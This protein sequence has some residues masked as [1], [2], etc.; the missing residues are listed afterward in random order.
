[1][2]HL[3][4]LR[5]NWEKIRTMAKN[6]LA[7]YWV[8]IEYIVANEPHSMTFSVVVDNDDLSLSSYDLV[9]RDGVSTT[10]FSQYMQQLTTV[11]ESRWNQNAIG[12]I[13]ATLYRQLVTDDIPLI[14]E[15][16]TVNPTL[17]NSAFTVLA[18]QASYMFYDQ[19]R[20]LYRMTLLDG[21]SEPFSRSSYAQ[22]SIGNQAIVDF[23]LA[24]DSCIV[25]RAGEYIT[26]FGQRTVTYNDKLTQK[27]FNVK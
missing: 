3:K 8:K 19:Q 4:R 26:T 14:L 20:N 12:F 6:T 1:M 22:L 11:L 21:I 27:Y 23:V 24:S 5:C 9:Q 7:P 10:D 16:A 13:S 25:T 17:T 2:K 18:S 15:V